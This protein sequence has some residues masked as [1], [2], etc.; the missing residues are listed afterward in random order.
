MSTYNQ[1]FRCGWSLKTSGGQSRELH[2]CSAP[3]CKVH[4]VI[5]CDECLKELNP[6]KGLFGKS[7]MPDKCP[8]CGV[9]ILS[10]V[11]RIVE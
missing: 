6:K 7:N 9:G 1:C 8:V 10:R 4:N 3:H 2:A 5:M 11:R